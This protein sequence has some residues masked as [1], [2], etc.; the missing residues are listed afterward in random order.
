MTWDRIQLT[1][2]FFQ[3][4]FL[5]ILY[6]H[7]TRKRLRDSS[8]LFKAPFSP[9]SIA[10]RS[11]T[12]QA[13]VLYRLIYANLLVIALEYVYRLRFAL[14]RSVWIFNI[15]RTVSSIRRLRISQLRN[16]TWFAN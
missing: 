6:I 9:S 16:K 8:M 11:M 10:T 13:K 4:T 3:E 15:I 1:V 12:E 7:Q 5:S 2:F 14:Y